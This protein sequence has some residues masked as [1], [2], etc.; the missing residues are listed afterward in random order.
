DRG[1]HRTSSEKPG[2]GASRLGRGARLATHFLPALDSPARSAAGRPLW[3]TQRPG[4]H[5][6]GPRKPGCHRAVGTSG[7]GG[8]AGGIS[9]AG[10]PAARVAGELLAALLRIAAV[11]LRLLRTLRTTHGAARGRDQPRD[12]VCRH[13]VARHQ[14]RSNVDGLWRTPP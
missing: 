13:P 9:V 3:R 14:R 4:E 11:V 2:T 12:A 5:A 7:P 10:W 6:P 8:V 1:R